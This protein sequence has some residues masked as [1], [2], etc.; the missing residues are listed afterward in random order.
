VNVIKKSCFAGLGLGLILL[1]SA[2][3][4]VFLYQ[5][6]YSF[7][8]A[9]FALSA[10]SALRTDGFYVFEGMAGQQGNIA[11]KPDVYEVYKF[12][13]SG[14]VNFLL[15]DMLQENGVYLNAMKDQI[16]AGEAGRTL[17]QGY[18]KIYGDKIIIEQ[19][20]T[21][22]TNFI[23]SYALVDHDTLTVVKK[24]I[25]GGGAFRADYFSGKS[26]LVYRFTPDEKAESELSPNW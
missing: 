7:Y 23:Y 1:V 21:V 19:V 14:Q 15:T 9:D 11:D 8:D 4:P 12:Y 17:F 6:D 26:T 24:T 2:C 20:N 3:M 22:T 10:N 18:Y 13:K 16:E 25:E 5:K